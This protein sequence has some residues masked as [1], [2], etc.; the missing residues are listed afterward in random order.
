MAETGG[1]A[2]KL[3]VWLVVLAIV[4]LLQ[5]LLIYHLV[6]P[7]S[8][9]ADDPERL[10]SRIEDELR[11]KSKSDWES[12]DRSLGTGERI[13]I[14]TEE[15]DAGYII[16]LS[17]RD[18]EDHTLNIDVDRD[19]ISVEGDFTQIEEKKDP[20]GTTISR[21]ERRESIKER[22]SIPANAD[23]RKAEITREKHRVVVSLPKY[24]SPE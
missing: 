21:Q 12:L 19:G 11:Q 1:R 23:Y 18:L 2:R 10:S 8:D 22:F 4:C 9:V 7:D 20:D 17:I 5:G 15:G 13:E 14:R 24:D 16:T 6:T 3:K